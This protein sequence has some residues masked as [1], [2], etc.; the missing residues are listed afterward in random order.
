MNKDT[1]P[2]PNPSV[3]LCIAQLYDEGTVGTTWPQVHPHG[4][5]LLMEQ[6]DMMAEKV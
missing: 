2:L 6:L 4:H 3:D 5:F 1:P